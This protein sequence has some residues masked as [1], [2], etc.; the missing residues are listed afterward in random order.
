VAWLNHPKS[1][2]VCQ[3][4]Y[5]NGLDQEKPVIPTQKAYWTRTV[6]RG[7]PFRDYSNIKVL[8]FNW[9][10]VYCLFRLSFH[11]VGKGVCLV[12]LWPNPAKRDKPWNYIPLEFQRYTKL[13]LATG[14]LYWHVE[15]VWG[16]PFPKRIKWKDCFLGEIFQEQVSDY[17]LTTKLIEQM[18]TLQVDYKLIDSTNEESWS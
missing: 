11:M 18:T 4:R 6:S 12:M 1:V 14:N 15:N 7:Q 9:S 5:I 2:Q 16:I 17:K 3:D 8:V 10:R 13:I